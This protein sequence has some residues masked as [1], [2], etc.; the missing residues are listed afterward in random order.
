M[1]YVNCLIFGYVGA[2]CGFS[3]QDVIK[4]YEKE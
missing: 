4:N 2:E 3:V 1:R